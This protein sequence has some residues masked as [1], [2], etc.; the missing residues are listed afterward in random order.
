[1]TSSPLSN[2]KFKS[3]FFVIFAFFA[4]IQI[5]VLIGLQIPIEVAV[6]DAILSNF[7]LALFC[8]LI[9]NNL[10]FYQ[11]SGNKY[12][13][14]IIWCLVLAS[15]NTLCFRYL[16]TFLIEADFYYL[17]VLNKSIQIRFLFSFLLIGCMAAISLVYYKLQDQQEFL[18]RKNEIDKL[19]K[20]AELTSLREK[21]QPHF[22]FNSLNS[23]SALTI[24][25]PI[26]ARKMV[27]QLSD[28]LRG[29][30]NND[31]DLSDL[32]SE[33]DH[34]NLYLEIEKVRFGERLNTNIE[35][36]DQALL[37]KIPPMLLQPIVENAIKFGLYDTLD[38]VTIS[39][40]SKYQ[41]QYLSI[42]VIN[43]FDMETSHHN[44]GTGFGLNSIKRRL[45]LL[46]NQQNLLTT[47]IREN[48]FVTT[49]LIPQA[50][51]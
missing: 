18:M 38:E 1:M 43:P 21:L 6:K 47:E 7:I 24:T 40:I 49:I 37:K 10:S 45:H 48:L 50:H 4:A 36:E 46:Y 19:T 16:N 26:Q 35:T 51:D 32:K 9:A 15:I 12:F 33:L 17:F 42:S 13:H 22:L 27:Q 8:W 41:N 29:T 34:L 30:I 25:K 20:D 11:P 3:A 14:V 39:I 23:I 2:T 28:F 44:K 5:W 31:E